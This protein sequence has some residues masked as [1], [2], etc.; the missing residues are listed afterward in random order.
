MD[1]TIITPIY[2][3]KKYIS[4]LIRIIENACLNV[5]NKQVEWILVNDYPEEL[6]P[7]IITKVKNLFIKVIVNSK[8]E[9]IHKARVNGLKKSNGKYILFLDQDDYIDS[10]FLQLQLANIKNADISVT[11]G[12]I[13]NKSRVKKKIFTTNYQMKALNNIKYYFY[14][15][16][17]ILSPGM[18]L[19]KKASI[20]NEWINNIL[21]INGSDDWL[22]WVLMLAKSARI[23]IINEY[24][25]IHT[26]TGE[27]TSNNI[28]GM[29]NSTEEALE[30]FNKCINT[31]DSENLINIFKKRIS[32]IRKYQLENKSKLKLYISNL[33]IAYYVI[34]Y[35]L[36]RKYL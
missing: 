25:Y 19:I 21:K 4:K 6:I 10:K 9:G 22:L 35:N 26:N 12:Y 30:V 31:Q 3:G 16:N 17:L 11:N 23:N 7:K 15:G 24:L 34:D 1:I 36:V 5:P 13:E 29:W 32:M 14:I 33:D 8:N 20:P 28:S 18:A 27:N 2:K